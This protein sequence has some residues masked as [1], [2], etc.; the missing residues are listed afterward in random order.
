M[1]QDR[2]DVTTWERLRVEP[3][4]ASEKVWLCEPG[5][6]STRPDGHWLFKPATV[7]ANGTRQVGDWTEAVAADIAAH[8]AIPAAQAQLVVR[9]GAQGVLSRNVR[10]AEYDMESGRLAMLDRISVALRDSARDG[11]ASIGHSLAN[12]RLTLDAYG[13]PPGA[14]SWSVCSGYDVFVGY[15]VLDAL[16]GNRDRHEQNWSVLRARSSRGPADSLAP[17]YDMEASLGFQL[18]DEA[19]RSRL[20]NADSLAAF[21][22][23]GLA[24]RFDGD[25]KVTLVDFAARAVEDCTSEGVRRIATLVEEIATTDFE[26]LLANRDGGVSE[27][28]RM[29][30]GAVLMING[31]RIQDAIRA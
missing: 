26:A 14:S 10:P 24:Q 6:S 3:R 11:T 30:A 7:H 4:G 21:A 28:T 13:P 12:I 31:R 9:D 17:A 2:V 19:K 5:G 22:R 16:I 8:L 23:K 20:A 18:T 27:A 1:S 29:F 25:R 15:L